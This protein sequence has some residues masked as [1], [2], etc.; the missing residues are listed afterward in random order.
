[1]K[2]I[3][4]HHVVEVDVTGQEKV[5]TS[6]YAFFAPEK[7]TLEWIDEG[8]GWKL[9]RAKLSGTKL[10]QNGL[11]GTQG[12]Y[13]QYADAWSATGWIGGH[14]PSFVTQVAQRLHPITVNTPHEFKPED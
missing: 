13:E 4:R 3:N 9:R 2:L 10:K 6:G 7:L 12:A 5:G 8:L 1:M 14:V 11:P